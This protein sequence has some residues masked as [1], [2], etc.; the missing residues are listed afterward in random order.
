GYLNEWDGRW[1]KNDEL[2]PDGTFYYYLD[3][4][5]GTKPRSGYVVIFR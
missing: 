5:D 4:G 3:L 2:L 1:Q